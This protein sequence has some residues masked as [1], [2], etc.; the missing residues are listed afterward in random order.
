MGSQFNYK[1]GSFKIVHNAP[2]DRCKIEYLANA[3][4]SSLIMARMGHLAF[5]DHES[6]VLILFAGSK[7]G[8][9][10]K[11]GAQRLLT[12]DIVIYDVKK[13]ELL[14]NIQFSEGTV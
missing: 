2:S 5:C 10:Y 11:Q 13:R 9:K 4:A 3:D 7:S 1:V 6:G 12:N 8:D 14:E